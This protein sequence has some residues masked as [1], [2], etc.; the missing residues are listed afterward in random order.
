MKAN[1]ALKLTTW[2]HITLVKWFIDILSNVHYGMRGCEPSMLI[3]MHPFSCVGK[4]P[5]TFEFIVIIKI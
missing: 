1:K 2:Q 4:N 5:Y 3:F